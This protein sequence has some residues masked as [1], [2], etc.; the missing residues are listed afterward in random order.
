MQIVSSSSLTILTKTNCCSHSEF[1]TPPFT[2]SPWTTAPG[3]AFLSSWIL[4]P[5][6]KYL[7]ML[8]PMDNSWTRGPPANSGGE[9][10][11][12]QD[13]R[14]SAWAKCC[15]RRW[16]CGSLSERYNSW[17]WAS[18]ASLRMW[19]LLVS[20]LPPYIVAV[21]NDAAQQKTY[22]IAS[23]NFLI[24]HSITLIFG[25]NVSH[26][27]HLLV[28]CCWTGCGR[29]KSYFLNKPPLRKAVSGLVAST[30]MIVLS[31]VRIVLQRWEVSGGYTIHSYH[32]SG[33]RQGFLI[34][35]Y[36]CIL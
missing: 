32:R 17:S 26:F 34:L 28:H 3:T 2:A 27:S 14:D 24:D 12:D 22:P 36:P 29:S 7:D 31:L 19:T 35:Q 33:G 11:K 13:C 20:N 16:G 4:P 21:P 6:L 1:Q 10:P 5:I 30:D 8:K 18:T 9:V 15:E 23:N 25:I